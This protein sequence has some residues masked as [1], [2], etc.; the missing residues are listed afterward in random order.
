MDRWLRAPA[1]GCTLACALLG[2][3]GCAS[4][5]E[6]PPEVAPQ[7]PQ[8]TAGEAAAEGREAAREAGNLR[9]TPT[10]R[11]IDEIRRQRENTAAPLDFPQ[12]LDQLHDQIYTRA[13]S[14]VEALDHRFAA[15]GAELKPVPAAPFRLGVIVESLEHSDGMKLNLNVDLDVS[16]KLPNIEE[17][18][19]IFVT[20]DE[21]DEGPRG[22]RE[23][24]F[25]RAGL[26]YQ[27]VRDISFD[28]GAKL[29]VPPVA[30][31]AVKWARQVRLGS[32][33]FYPL[34]KLFA[35]T[36]ES[37]GY[38]AAAT[39]DRWSGRHLLR[40]S[41]FAKWRNDRDRTEWSQTLIYARTH[42]ILVPERYGS[43]L[44]ADDI[45][46]GWGVRLLAGGE[47][48]SGVSY[49][50]AGVFY[51]R[52]ARLN[53]WLYW[54]VEPLVRWDRDYSWSADPGIRFGIHALF[55]DLARPA[56][57]SLQ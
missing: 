31:A 47:R 39:F 4:T 21:L 25:L 51:R 22:A 23:D 53:N 11:S 14:F 10:S 12:R 42:E 34:V 7:P 18:L 44:K 2:L 55:W 19:R 26:R 37:V 43:Y 5:R 9:S 41:S 46:R 33:D 30:F 49:Y 40:S 52:P 1:A 35:E 20:S 50:E 54:Y 8:I 45:G 38:T 36:D 15:P 56:R 16:L 24:S 3:A 32:W 27:F 28:I 48:T 17:R 6:P 13:Q 57:G 29:D